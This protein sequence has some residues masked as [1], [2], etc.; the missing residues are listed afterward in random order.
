MQLTWTDILRPFSVL[1][2][3]QVIC[4]SSKHFIRYIRSFLES[5]VT[6]AGYSPKARLLAKTTAKR[7]QLTDFFC[8]CTLSIS[9]RILRKL[10]RKM[11]LSV[12]QHLGKLSHFHMRWL[13][14]VFIRLI[15]IKTL[16]FS[17]YCILKN[18][19]FRELLFK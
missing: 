5:K 19:Y 7:P 1:L 2:W 9:T 10:Q 3:K 14:E 18:R 11:R 17:N 15:D 13:N 4:F 8:C 12:L 16:R 6:L